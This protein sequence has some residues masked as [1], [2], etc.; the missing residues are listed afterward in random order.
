MVWG[1][2]PIATK[3]AV[4]HVSALMVAILRTVGAAVLLLPVVCRGGLPRPRGASEWVPLV[5]SGFAGFVGFPVFFTYG[6]QLT[7]ASHA[8]L[9]LALSPVSTGLIAALLEHHRLSVR[10]IAGAA[11]ALAGAVALVGLRLGLQGAPESVAGDALVLCALLWSTAG[12][13]VGARASRAYGSWSTTVWG[14]LVSGV[15]VLPAFALLAPRTSWAAV[16]SGEWIALGYLAVMVS[17]AAYVAWY[18]ALAAGGIARVGLAQFTQPVVTV[19]LALVMLG[20]PLTVPLAAAGA[21]I[22]AGISLAR[23]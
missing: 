11:V 19:A 18:W 4:N 23:Q 17:I 3:I 16:T 6:L 15:V 8:A 5:V 9:I 14:I 7:T 22:L 20:E 12:Y 10:W 21:C 2:S 13:V 1:A